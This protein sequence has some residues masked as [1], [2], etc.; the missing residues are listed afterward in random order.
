MNSDAY[1]QTC[2]CLRAPAGVLAHLSADVL[3]VARADGVH[4]LLADRVST[5]ALTAELRDAA[6][7]ETLRA[8]ELR[9]VL[10]RLADSGV[11]AVLLKGAALAYTHY[12]QPELRPRSDTDLMIPASARAET[13]RVLAGLGYERPTEIDGEVAIGQSHFLRTDGYGLEHSLDVHWRVSNVRAFADVLTYEEL[14]RDAGA[15]PPLGLDAFCAS[16]VHALIVACVHRVAHHGDAPNL[17]WL[18]D[19]HLIARAMTP[20]ERA[21]FAALAAQRRVLAVCTRTLTLAQHAF[22]GIDVAWIVS[23]RPAEAAREPTAAFVGGR[24]RQIDILKS[25]FAETGWPLRVQLL[26]EHLFPS[27]SYM[28]Q[29]FPR[30]PG[31]LLPVAYV[32]RI[33]AGAPRWLRR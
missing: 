6:V 2:A 20:A 15:V 19:V 14:A 10:G 27:A 18:Y 3:A 16:A 33:V 26:R 23:M 12:R 8:R 4:L 25:D 9:E 17:L 13:A 31:V 29:R 21:A 1:E 28:R 24:L 30:W 7:V 22:G 11:H 32:C 5:P